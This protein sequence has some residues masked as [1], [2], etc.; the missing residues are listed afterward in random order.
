MAAALDKRVLIYPLDNRWRQ[1]SRLY[2]SILDSSKGKIEVE[3]DDLEFDNT[4]F[5]TVRIPEELHVLLV[6]SASDMTYLRIALTSR[7]T[8]S[9]ASV[10][11][12]QIP[13]DHF[14]PSQL[15]NTD[16]IVLANVHE[17]TR[18]QSHALKT[19]LQNGGG[20]LFFPGAQTTVDAFNTSIAAPL[21]VSPAAV[22]G[23]NLPSAIGSFI[24]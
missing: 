13:Y 19:F 23:G 5:F 4:R 21:G 24:H 18:D 10:I 12:H 6:G 14:S 20:M 7:L 16:V 1:N 22:S 15:N 9:S 3:D 17:L 2:Q 8:D 11:V